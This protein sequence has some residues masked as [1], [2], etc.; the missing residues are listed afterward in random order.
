M[1]GVTVASLNCDRVVIN[2]QKNQDLPSKTFTLGDYFRGFAEFTFKIYLIMGTK[3]YGFP[4]E[5]AGFRTDL[6]WRVMI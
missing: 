6:G 1:G 2:L 4:K 5:N 3:M